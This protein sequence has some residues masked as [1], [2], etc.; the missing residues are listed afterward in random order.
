MHSQI[1]NMYDFEEDEIKQ[2]VIGHVIA[3]R[4]MYKEVL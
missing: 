3:K 1:L 2:R 4:G